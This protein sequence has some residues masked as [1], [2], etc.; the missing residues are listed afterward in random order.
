MRDPFPDGAV[1]VSVPARPDQAYL[2]RAVTASVAARVP[3]SFD[4]IE[5]LKLAVDEG[6]ARLLAV[7]D[8]ATRMELRL[9]ATGDRLEASVSIDGDVGPWPPPRIEESF[10]WRV[11]S[12]LVD[13]VTLDLDGGGPT[14]RMT[15]SRLE[16]STSPG[17]A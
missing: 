7:G 16:P 9:V 14:V 11:L 8:Q 15:K 13:T 10:S 3:L 4:D 5:D 6:C 1:V 12:A 2:L 17:Q